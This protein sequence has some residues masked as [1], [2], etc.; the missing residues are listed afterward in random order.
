MAARQA[1][2]QKAVP[3]EMASATHWLDDAEAALHKGQ[4]GHARNSALHAKKLAVAALRDAS[5][6]GQEAGEGCP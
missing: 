6:A 5:Q 1:C 4:Y 3:D 2:A